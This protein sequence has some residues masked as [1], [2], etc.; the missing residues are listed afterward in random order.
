M[1]MM[2]W[3]D[4]HASVLPQTTFRMLALKKLSVF[5][6]CVVNILFTKITKFSV[7]PAICRVK[8]EI[9]LLL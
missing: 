8:V 4:F 3:V 1:Q 6:L 7:I 9:Q 5:S 2:D